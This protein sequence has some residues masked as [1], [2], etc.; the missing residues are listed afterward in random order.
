MVT[1]QTVTGT[2]NTKTPRIVTI[3]A[4]VTNFY[5]DVTITGLQTLGGGHSGSVV[6]LSDSAQIYLYGVNKSALSA[7]L[8]GGTH[9]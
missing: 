6:L 7:S 9:I 2:G 3:S 4:G 8:I 5:D 1:S